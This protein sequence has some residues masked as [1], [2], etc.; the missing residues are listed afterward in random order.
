MQALSDGDK[1]FIKLKESGAKPS[2]AFREAYP[3]HEAVVFWNQ[4]KAGTV[5]RQKASE[6]LAHAAK[7]KLNTRYIRRA[8]ATYHD[9]MEEFSELSLETATDLVKNARS[10]KVR[11]DLAIEGIRHKV[12]TPVQ[13]VAVQERKTVYLT[14]DEPPKDDREIIEGEL[15]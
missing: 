11:S 4:T 10:E 5:Q 15:V 8:M 13:K 7:R 12:G 9:K 3:E 6:V 2:A 14:F 1:T